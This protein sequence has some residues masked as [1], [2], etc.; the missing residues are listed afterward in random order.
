MQKCEWSA[1]TPTTVL[2]TPSFDRNVSKYKTHNM[3]ELAK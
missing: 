3:R 2:D 1:W